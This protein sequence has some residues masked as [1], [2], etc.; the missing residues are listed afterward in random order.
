MWDSLKAGRNNKEVQGKKNEITETLVIAG[1]P[2]HGSHKTGLKCICCISITSL[3]LKQRRY[4]PIEVYD[5]PVGPSSYPESDAVP[6]TSFVC[7][8]P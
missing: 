3:Q 1:F 5:N 6:P 7:P 8:W 4:P 2:H